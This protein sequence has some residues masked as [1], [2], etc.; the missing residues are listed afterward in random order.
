MTPVGITHSLIGRVTTRYDQTAVSFLVFVEPAYL[1]QIPV[2]LRSA[3]T[4]GGQDERASRRRVL[5]R[6]Q[7]IES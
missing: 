5:G 7:E 4:A 6:A 1:D 2:S 3:A